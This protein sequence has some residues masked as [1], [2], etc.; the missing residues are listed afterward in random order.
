MTTSRVNNVAT[1]ADTL[2]LH[3]VSYRIERRVVRSGQCR[4]ARPRVKVTGGLAGT[5]EPWHHPGGI[6]GPG[7]DMVG[8]HVMS[9]PEPREARGLSG[10]DLDR[11]GQ[12]DAIWANNSTGG[13]ERRGDDAGVETFVV[14]GCEIPAQQFRYVYGYSV[15]ELD[16][17]YP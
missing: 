17:L 7:H 13:Q 15:A 16:T 10:Q 6:S 1:Q 8:Q 9:C 2:T 3:N 14:D 4:G 5:C 12:R 11:T